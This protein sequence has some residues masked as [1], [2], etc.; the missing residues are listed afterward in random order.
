MDID[1]KCNF[2]SVD[3]KISRN[4]Y[5]EFF[6]I[7]DLVGNEGADGYAIISS[8]SLDAESNEVLVHTDKGW[9]HIDFIFK[10]EK[11]NI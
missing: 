10:V 3:G 6:K 8:F 2:I 4:S 11:N 7:G 9:A 1:L 5:G